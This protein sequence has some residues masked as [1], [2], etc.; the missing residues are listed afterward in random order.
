[1]AANEPVELIAAAGQEAAATNGNSSFSLPSVS[2]SPSRIVHSARLIYCSIYPD[3]TKSA[4]TCRRR[5]DRQ[6][7]V[8]SPPLLIYLGKVA[9]DSPHPRLIESHREELLK[10]LFVMTGQDDTDADHLNEFLES[11]DIANMDMD[12]WNAFLSKRKMR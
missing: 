7:K 10:E 6:A 12:K 11:E 4:S 9:L 1:M 3:I 8:S 2:Q 5:E